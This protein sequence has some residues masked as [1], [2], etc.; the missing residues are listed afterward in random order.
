MGR[1]RLEAMMLSCEFYRYNCE[2]HLR[3]GIQT[4]GRAISLGFAKYGYGRF[5]MSYLDVNLETGM[6]SS[7]LPRIIMMTS[8]HRYPSYLVSA[9]TTR[10]GGAYFDP[11]NS[12]RASSTDL[13]LRHFGI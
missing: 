8:T 10:A 6:M 1:P 12:F 7:V 5:C 2:E 9:H 3:M 4:V 11:V 13:P